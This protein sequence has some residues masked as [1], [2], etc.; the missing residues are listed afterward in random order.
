MVGGEGRDWRWNQEIKLGERDDWVQGG[1]RGCLMV[2][3]MMTKMV[4]VILVWF[5]FRIL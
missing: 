3:D 5:S 2:M 4:L 1:H